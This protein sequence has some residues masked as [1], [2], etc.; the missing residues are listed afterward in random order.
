VQLNS[1]ADLPQQ[2]KA[3]LISIVF[4]PGTTGEVLKWKVILTKSDTVQES[5]GT[6]FTVRP[7]ASQKSRGQLTPTV[8][9]VG[10][11]KKVL[12][13]PSALLTTHVSVGVGVGLTGVAVTVGVGVG[14]TV[15]V[16]VGVIDAVGKG[17]GEGVGRSH[18]MEI[19]S[20]L[21]P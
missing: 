9:S 8:K 10:G 18:V 21:Q 15:T 2:V 17:V 1:G 16:G 13:Q 4:T 19:S 12:P 5:A 3:P 6:L 14:V 20:T 7:L 11:V